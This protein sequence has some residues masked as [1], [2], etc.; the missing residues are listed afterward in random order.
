MIQA[1]ATNR[2]IEAM[3][4]YKIMKAFDERS[5][6]KRTKKVIA[7]L[8]GVGWKKVQRWMKSPASKKAIDEVLIKN[9]NLPKPRRYSVYAK[10]DRNHETQSIMNPEGKAALKR[11]LRHSQQIYLITDGE[12]V[13]IGISNNVEKRLSDLQVAHP[14][15][16]SLMRSFRTLCPALN[17]E[18]ILHQILDEIATTPRRGEWFKPRD[19]SRT[20]FFVSKLI[21]QI[22]QACDGHVGSAGRM[23][24][25]VRNQIVDEIIDSLRSRGLA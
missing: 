25:G 23:S 22:D 3:G 21:T 15:P 14:K 17:I 20:P 6:G 10:R 1:T 19:V 4:R 13:K 5:T 24:K 11:K 16:L 9:P 2:E 18:W 8:D 7:N 12:H